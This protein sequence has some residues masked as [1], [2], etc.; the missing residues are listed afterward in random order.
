MFERVRHRL[1][2]INYEMNNSLNKLERK[3][4]VNFRFSTRKSKMYFYFI[5]GSEERV[6]VSMSSLL[7]ERKWLDQPAVCALQQRLKIG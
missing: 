2:K 3:W 7:P 5:L 1:V 4:T 6:S